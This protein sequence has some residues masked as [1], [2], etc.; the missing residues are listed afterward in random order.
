M[1]PD[2][3]D[4]LQIIE[5][6]NTIAASRLDLEGVM[7]VVVDCA[8]R[9]T[10]AGGAAIE[11]VEG[12]EMVYRAVSGSVSHSLG[13]RLRR[14][15]SLSGLCVN[16]RV[17]LRSD[18]TSTDPRVDAVACRHVGAAS[19][20]CVPLVHADDV[21]GVLKLVSGTPHAFAERAQ[22]VIEI[23]A[24]I[25]ATSMLHARAH[26]ETVHET[27][28]DPLTGLLNRRAFEAQLDE[29]VE[30]NRRYRHGLCLVLLDLDAFKAANDRWGH[31]AGDEI[32]RQ[33]AAIMRSTARPVDNG[34]RLGGNEFAM[35][36]PNTL[37]PDA[38]HV[39]AKMREA[40]RVAALGEGTI[41]FSAGLA[42]HTGELPSE[43]VDKADAALL[44]DKKEHR[45]P[46]AR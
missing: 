11:V 38:L 44:S 9:L 32:L 18:D 23:L 5:L 42:E 45:P 20:V 34:F 16:Q 3:A 12:D 43:L 10:R 26:E 24:K 27:L 6:Q 33:T 29:E 28:H 36:M 46:S 37:L 15:K 39:V 35:L 2:A 8:Q 17:A 25:V 7:R 13:L 30:R 40:F 1:G 31:P 4:L 19:M 41:V 22:T 14:E 21:V